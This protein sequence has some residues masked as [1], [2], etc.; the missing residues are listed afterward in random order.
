MKTRDRGRQFGQMLPCPIELEESACH[1]TI[2]LRILALLRKPRG[3]IDKHGVRTLESHHDGAADQSLCEQRVRRRVRHRPRAPLP[4]NVGDAFNRLEVICDDGVAPLAFASPCAT[5]GGA[6]HLPTDEAR[7]Q[8]PIN[9]Y[10]HTNLCVE[11]T[12]DG[13]DACLGLR[14]LAFPYFN[15][16]GAGSGASSVG[17]T[18][19]RRI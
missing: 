15:A 2:P 18:I 4:H 7:A 12:L 3:F 6:E 8:R 13:F 19:P 17:I 11:A 14:S 16:G 10:G 5:Y 9:A 1:Q